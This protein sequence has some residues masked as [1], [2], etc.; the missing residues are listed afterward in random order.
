MDKWEK[1]ANKQKLFKELRESLRNFI[2]YIKDK[3]LTKDDELNIKMR[4]NSLGY[5]NEDG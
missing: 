2:D 4:L 1:R 3:E 5:Y